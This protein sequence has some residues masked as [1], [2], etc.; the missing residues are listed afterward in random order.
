[1]LKARIVD[2]RGISMMEM[3][4][5][6]VIV[7]L[8]AAI[9]LPTL[10]G[11]RQVK[12]KNSGREILSSF[13]LARSSAITLQEP[14]GVYFDTETGKIV[15]F[16]DRTNLSAATFDPPQDSVVRIDSLLMPSSD[17]ADV[18][19]MIY[20]GFPNQTVV[21]Y[22]D[23]RAS[24]TGDVYL[25]RYDNDGMYNSLSIYVTAA[26]GRARLEFLDG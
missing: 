20:T 4:I 24:A 1:M 19:S 13:R 9:A 3:M 11:I 7:G 6:V 15:V 23:G 18:G 12:F 21:F 10:D 26:T 22:P 25:H 16:A 2:S 14:H 5:A 17:G 8:L